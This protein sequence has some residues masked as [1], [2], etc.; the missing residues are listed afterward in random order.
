MK[1]VK[2]PSEA[3]RQILHKLIFGTRLLGSAHPMIY[4]GVV[5]A[6]K[7]LL[8]ALAR[9]DLVLLLEDVHGLLRSPGGVPVVEA[10]AG[11]RA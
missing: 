6:L 10:K 7:E 9:P 3:E 11:Q 2:E 1:K 5:G 8:G 4:N